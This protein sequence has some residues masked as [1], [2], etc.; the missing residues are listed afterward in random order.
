M[1]KVF[2]DEL[3]RGGKGINKDLINWKESIGNTIHFIY[4]NIAVFSLNFTRQTAV[5]NF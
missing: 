2:L 3:P 5:R 1:R 4:D